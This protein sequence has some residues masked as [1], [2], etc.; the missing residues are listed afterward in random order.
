MEKRKRP[1]WEWLLVVVL[2][3]L[4]VGLTA[5]TYTYQQRLV[6][7]QALHYQLQLLR[8]AELLYVAVNK[9]APA[10]VGQLIDGTFQLPGDAVVHRFIEHPPMLEEGNLID[11]FGNP[12]RYDART[13]WFKSQTPGYEFW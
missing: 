9:Q 8:T 6:K 7:S 11:P 4:T 13:G 5:A 12:Y 10:D 3:V 2:V 1:A